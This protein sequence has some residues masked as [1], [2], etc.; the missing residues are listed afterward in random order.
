M[1]LAHLLFPLVL[2]ATACEIGTGKD[3]DTGLDPEGDTDTDTDADTDTDTDADGDTDTDTD[4]DTDAD[5]DA[6]TD[7][8]ADCEWLDDALL[9]DT[10]MPDDEVEFEPAYFIAS[11]V[12]MVHESEVYD[13]SYDGTDQ[14]SYIEFTFFGDSSTSYAELCSI[15]YDA[16]EASPPAGT[17]VTDSGGELFDAFS[18]EL[19]DGYTDCGV[20]NDGSWGSEDMRDVLEKWQWGVGIG[21]MVSVKDDLKPAVED[22]GLDWTND[23][24]PYVVSGYLYWDLAGGAL[25]WM[26]TFGYDTRCDEAIID[27]DG[28]LVPLDAPTSKP[29][30]T[31]LWIPN[32]FYYV[33]ASYL[34]H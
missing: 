6:D 8:D 14:T 5:A 23:W 1:K 32:G 26:Y 9:A 30:E 20:L 11:A 19:A 2:F 22:A 13:F 21:Q 17:W 15:I 25:E 34:A 3:D 16:S 27:G 7:A 31:G 10:G 33:D 29:I 4:A 12:I 28:Y 18:F 24:E